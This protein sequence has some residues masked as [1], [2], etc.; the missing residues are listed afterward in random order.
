MSITTTLPSAPST[1]SPSTFEPDMDAF[2]RALPIFQAELDAYAASL[3]PLGRNMLINPAFQIDQRSAGAST[4]TA[5]DAYCFDGWYVLTQ[6]GTVAASQVSDP[7]NGYTHALRLTQSQ[8]SAQRFGFAQIIE[9]KNCKFARGNS[10]T[11]VA[12]VRCSA[13]TTIRYA[14]L[15]WT[16]T[17]DAVTSD[18]VNSWTNATFT[19]GNFF[20]STTLSVLGTGSL[21][22]TSTAW[23]S[24]TALTASL[25]SSFTNIIVM[26]WTDSTQAQ[27]VTLDCDYAQFEAGASANS[28]ERRN[29]AQELMNCLRY[30]QR[31]TFTA[32][33]SLVGV[34]AASSSTVA[35]A[36]F[37]FSKMRVAPTTVTIP[38]AGN[39]SGQASFL[40]SAA[41][42]PGGYGT[43]ACTVINDFCI[44]IDG[45]G[46]TGLNSGAPSLF[47]SAAGGAHIT[48]SADL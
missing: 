45:S 9:G 13:S 23:T 24:L 15:G 12:R 35:N 36:Y 28:F 16:G 44:R 6:T 14:I 29:Y 18:V 11:F 33:N 7:E 30:Y 37:Q 20:N 38:A 31:H 3:S 40:T 4:A 34:G 42:Q 39:G 17:E 25:G 41:A 48:L 1:S 46:Y 27:N 2:L 32:A 47:F 10:G 5:D 19:A 21:A 43:N 26:V 8:A 22:V